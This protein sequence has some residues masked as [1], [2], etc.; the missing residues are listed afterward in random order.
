L[1]VALG[2]TLMF[3]VLSFWLPMASR[4]L[5]L[6]AIGTLGKGTKS[7]GHERVSSR[8]SAWTR[9]SGAVRLTRVVVLFHQSFQMCK[10]FGYKGQSE[11]GEAV[12]AIREM[13]QFGL[14][15]DVGTVAVLPKDDVRKVY[16]PASNR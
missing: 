5:V 2:A 1:S 14:C 10:V 4:P 8:R 6:A 7:S 16:F 15:E 3:R 11:Q 13:N 9:M 12:I